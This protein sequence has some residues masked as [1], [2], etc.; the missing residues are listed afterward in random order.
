MVIILRYTQYICD[1]EIAAPTTKGWKRE[2]SLHD[3]YFEEFSSPWTRIVFFMLPYLT[4]SVDYIVPFLVDVM[5][6]KDYPH[7][8]SYLSISCL[9]I[10]PC[11]E[12]APC[13]EIIQ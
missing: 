6:S 3:E 12:K 2:S 9:P 1:K 8:V 4:H 10:G 7:R 5:F 13:T 11:L